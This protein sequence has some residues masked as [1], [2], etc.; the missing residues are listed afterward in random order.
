MMLNSP[1]T[2]VNGNALLVELTQ[3]EMALLDCQKRISLLQ[4]RQS[5]LVRTLDDLTRPTLKPRPAI[6]FAYQGFEYRGRFIPCDSE[7]DIHRT[8]LR[9]LWEDFPQEREAMA[10]AMA[11]RGRLRPY[12][13]R[14][15]LALFPGKSLSWAQRYSASL[16]DGWYVDTNLNRE[17]IHL[18]LIAAVRTAGLVWEID[19]KV[20]WRTRVLYEHSAK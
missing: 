8:M 18:L 9:Q 17:R 4:S 6:K 5:D 11:R 1:P 15:P 7:I 3:T 2:S 16:P 19:V 12:V 10:R 20:N 13:A 14:S